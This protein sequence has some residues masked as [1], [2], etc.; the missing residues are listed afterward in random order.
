[1]ISSLGSADH[2]RRLQLTLLPLWVDPGV[3]SNTTGCGGNTSALDHL[4][5][6]ARVFLPASPAYLG[7]IKMLTN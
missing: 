6:R 4:M 3:W 5:Y 2:V 1:M 7:F